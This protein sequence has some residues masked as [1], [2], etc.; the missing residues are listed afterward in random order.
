MSEQMLTSHHHPLR[1]LGDLAVLGIDTTKVV[2]VS[3]PVVVYYESS[4]DPVLMTGEGVVLPEPVKHMVYLTSRWLTDNLIER[5][6]ASR[7]IFWYPTLKYNAEEKLP[8]GFYGIIRL[9]FRYDA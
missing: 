6:N 9:R 7:G 4:T 2:E 5:I 1:T 3:A 8:E